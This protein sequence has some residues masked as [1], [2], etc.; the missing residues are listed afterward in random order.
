MSSHDHHND[1]AHDN[2][3]H[4]EQEILADEDALEEIIPDGDDAPMDSDDD[5][6][7]EEILLE[8]DSIT[9]FDV[10]KDS[11]FAIAQHPLHPSLI[12]T[13]GSEGEEDDARKSVV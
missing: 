3:D 2:N 13:G 8:N 12:A 1:R 5:N 4:D 11:V 9:Y 10:H 7:N 6:D